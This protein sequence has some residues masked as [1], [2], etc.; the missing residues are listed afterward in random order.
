M[1]VSYVDMLFETPKRRFDSDVLGGL[2]LHTA[3]KQ[4]CK[5]GMFGTISFLGT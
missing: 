3:Q 4:V 1:Q 5:E 2:R